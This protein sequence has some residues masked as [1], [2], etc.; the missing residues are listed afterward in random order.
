MFKPDVCLAIGRSR[1]GLCQI[2]LIILNFIL[3]FSPQRVVVASKIN[4]EKTVL[5]VY[6]PGDDREVKRV[7]RVYG[8]QRIDE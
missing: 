1:Q 7:L 6:Q 3:L 2:V 8:N 4:H 5:F